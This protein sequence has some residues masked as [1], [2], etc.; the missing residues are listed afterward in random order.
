[1]F[2]GLWVRSLIYVVGN[3]WILAGIMDGY[4]REEVEVDRARSKENVD[5]DKN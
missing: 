3:A 1:V 2:Y 4:A 5:S